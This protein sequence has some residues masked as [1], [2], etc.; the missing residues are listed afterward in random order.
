MQK[1]VVCMVNKQSYY[2]EHA[3]AKNVPLCKLNKR[4]QH[5]VVAV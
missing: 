3:R 5:I 4:I 1:C 2:Q